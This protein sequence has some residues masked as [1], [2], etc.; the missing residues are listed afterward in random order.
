MSEP[1]LVVGVAHSLGELHRLPRSDAA[2]EHRFAEDGVWVIERAGK[3]DDP[4]GVAV[5]A[6]CRTGWWRFRD[7]RIGRIVRLGGER[8]LSVTHF[9]G[10]VGR[11]RRCRTTPGLGEGRHGRPRVRRLLGQSR[12]PRTGFGGLGRTRVPRRR[13]VR[14]RAGSLGANARPHARSASAMKVALS[15]ARAAV[16][17]STAIAVASSVRPTAGSPEANTHRPAVA[18]RDR[19]L[20]SEDVRRTLQKSQRRQRSK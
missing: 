6:T 18:I 8:C 17:V 11:L 3:V 13:T 5:V 2:V 16:T 10:T 9:T 7:G 1:D 12:V 4:A 19:G 20:V 14:A 15:W